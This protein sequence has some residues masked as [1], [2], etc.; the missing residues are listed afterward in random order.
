VQR[1][2]LDLLLVGFPLHQ[3]QFVRADMVRLVAS[4]LASL[5]RRDMSL[6]RRLFSWLLGLEVNPSHFP[7][8][9][10]MGLQQH[11]RLSSSSEEEG[12]LPSPYFTLYTKG[13]DPAAFMLTFYYLKSRSPFP[14]F[15]I[16][17]LWLSGPGYSFLRLSGIK[18]IES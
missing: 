12:A 10:P 3:P 17:Y 4:V 2:A 16:S 15:F 6:N 9:H 11:Q 5:L 7:A 13:R 14:P 1:A 18:E 8:S